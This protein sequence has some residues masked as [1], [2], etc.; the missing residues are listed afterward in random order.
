MEFT[1][2]FMKEFADNLGHLLGSKCEIAIHDF[3]GDMEHTIVHLVN[4]EVSGR[5]VGGCPT[6]L[7][8]KQFKEDAE[9]K[10]FLSEYYTTLEDGRTIRSS[11]TIMTDD[12]GKLMASVCVNMDI[13][14][15]I[16]L[17]DHCCEMIGKRKSD[18]SLVGNERF[19]MNV[20]DLLQHCLDAAEK[21]IGKPA[22]E[23]NRKEK[24]KA[25]AYLDGCGVL[26]I[27]KAHVVLCEFFNISK[28][29]LYNYLEEVRSGGE[30]HV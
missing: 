12:Q 14:D 17:K 30:P 16:H 11:T 24:L 2:E 20:Q 28:F 4:G 21:S 29:T 19:D 5:Q 15:L 26:Q 22:A 23:M 6:N 8:F 9:R 18:E 1:Y 13:T 3:T 27:A 7:F 10:K 25:L